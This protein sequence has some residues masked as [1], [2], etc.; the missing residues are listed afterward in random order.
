MGR[1]VG[2]ACMYLF[3]SLLIF[4]GNTADIG[5]VGNNLLG[6]FS[7]TGTRLTTGDIQ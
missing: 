7:L 6:V 2:R 1:R 3:V 5:E 4:L